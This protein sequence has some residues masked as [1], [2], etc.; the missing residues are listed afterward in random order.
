MPRSAEAPGNTGE[1]RRLAE[2]AGI[3]EIE[4]APEIAEPV[5]DRGAGERDARALAIFLRRASGQRRDF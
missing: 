4:E 1:I 3:E 2:Q 5:L